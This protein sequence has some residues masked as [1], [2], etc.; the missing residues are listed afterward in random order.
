MRTRNLGQTSWEGTAPRRLSRRL[1]PGLLTLAMSGA[2]FG[3]ATTNASAVPDNT[4]STTANVHVDSFI[5]LTGLTPSFSLHGL[6]GATVSTTEPIAMTVTTNSLAGY[7]VTVQSAADTL[8]PAAAGNTNSI[9]IANL[10]VRDTEGN[11][12][13]LSDTT[14]VTV[15]SQNTRSSSDGDVLSNDYSVDIP[16]VNVDT[17]SVVLDYVAT[18][19]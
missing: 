1:L 2:I 13:S 11:F 18:S 8:A 15:H 4:G 9:P 17:Y 7:D 14:A 19:S 6:P 10:K 5:T 12:T 16:F 3:I